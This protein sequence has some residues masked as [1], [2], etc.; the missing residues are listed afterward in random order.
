[1]RTTIRSFAVLATAFGFAAA[2]GVAAAH[3]AHHHRNGDHRSG[4]YGSGNHR[5][6]DYR[7]GQHRSGTY[8]TYGTLVRAR[9]F[10][11]KAASANE[12][13]I[14]TGQLAQQKAQSAA[15]RDLGA[16]FVTDHTALLAQGA[17]VAQQ[18]GV[19]A[20]PTLNGYQQAVVNRLSTLSGPAF[21]AAWLRA[22]LAAHQSALALNLAGA[23]RGENTAIRTLA[24]G[25]LPVV[26]KHFGELIDLATAQRSTQHS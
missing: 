3:G 19:S 1:M 15:I 14:V 26:A 20:P 8:G 18:L 13:E 12:F 21:D 10:L 7:N 22:Q 17:Q 5:N 24:Q 23:I 2:P 9:V 11:P 4:D 6:G 16:M 25:A